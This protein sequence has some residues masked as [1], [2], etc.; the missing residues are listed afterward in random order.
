MSRKWKTLTLALT[1]AVISVTSFILITSA[2]PESLITAPATQ[3][4]TERKTRN[5]SLQPE[6]FRVSRRLGARFSPKARGS[7]VTTGNL[8]VGTDQQIATIIRRQ[9]ENGESVEVVLGGRRLTWSETEGV[10][11]IPSS[12]TE[13]DRLLAEQ[14]VFDSPD[15]FVLAQL[16]GAS[17]FTVAR[18]V[19]SASAADN[20]EGPLWTVV[21][22][23]DPQQNEQLRPRS[24]W[25]LYYIS[26]QTGLIERVVSQLNGKTIEAEV[27]AWS[28]QGGEKIPSKI[29][30]SIDGRN[31]MSYQVNTFSHSD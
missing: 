18:N 21:R 9:T 31:L 5:L 27:L 24:S 15:Q 29:N 3:P 8:I 12:P 30:W 7:T 14:L 22:V 10:R 25:R 16:R 4:R 1:V 6:A 23:D 20:Y 11:G 2:S 13:T 19:R 28:E 26:S 17:Y